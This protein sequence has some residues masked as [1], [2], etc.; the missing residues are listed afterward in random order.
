MILLALQFI[1]VCFMLIVGLLALSGIIVCMQFA[2][3]L[4]LNILK[5][6]SK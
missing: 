4:F 5:G 3:Q 6:G 1:S 2:W